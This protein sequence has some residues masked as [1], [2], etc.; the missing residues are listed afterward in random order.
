M[1]IVG[2]AVTLNFKRPIFKRLFGT[3][4]IL[5]HNALSVM[6]VLAQ[7]IIASQRIECFFKSIL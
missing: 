1:P 7:A 4:V 5:E 6:L 3:V 2:G